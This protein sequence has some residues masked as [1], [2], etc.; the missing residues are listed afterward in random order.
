MRR[1]RFNVGRVLVPKSPP[2]RAR[3]SPRRPRRRTTP[4]P[5]PRRPRG[6]RPPPATQRRRRHRWL[7]L[8]NTIQCSGGGRAPRCRTSR[9]LLCGQGKCGDATAEAE[10]ELMLAAAEEGH[11]RKR[12][13]RRGRGGGGGGGDGCLSELIGSAPIN[14]A[15]GTGLTPAVRRMQFLKTPPKPL[16]ATQRVA[17]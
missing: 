5:P 13:R 11:R 6:T 2:A 14:P 4:C 12:R 8:G 16:G 15:R 1:R 10:E 17:T 3:A 9:I 7:R